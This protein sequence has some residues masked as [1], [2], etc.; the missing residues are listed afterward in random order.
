MSKFLYVR[1]VILIFL[2][3]CFQGHPVLAC[4]YNVRETGFI[5]L[6]ADPYY[7]YG[8]VSENTP[9]EIISGF[10]QISSTLLVDCNIRFEIININQQKDHPGMKFFYLWQIQSFPAAILVSP[11]GQSLIIPI[12]E[13]NEPFDKTLRSAI[14]NIVM[15]P[16]RAEIIGKVIETYGVILLVKGKDTRE[17]RK[18]RETAFY[19]IAEIKKQMRIMPKSITHPPVL[20]VIEPES[21]TREKILLWSLGLDVDEIEKPYA[22]VFY[23]RA[24][25]IGPLMKAEE[26]SET[27][28]INILSIVG[29]DCECGF[30]VSWVQG[31]ILPI[32]W[33]KKIQA[34]ATESLEF[35]PE[36]P[37]VKME[38]N[39]I[40]RM[41][42]SSY[43]GVPVVYQD[44]PGESESLS[45][46]YVI[47]ENNSRLKVTKYFIVGL[48]VIITITALFIFIRATR[49]KF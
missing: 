49:S 39:H 2:W 36:N 45:E 26:I 13:D 46:P 38:V 21:F 4:R 6:G 25:W 16:I 9:E 34:K 42:L 11:D 47:D 15:S 14:D 18:Y 33:D 48:A 35:D 17:N 7:L 31:T 10:K 27:N 23:G 40:L 22:A 20:I 32:R 1:L 12:K 5:D 24:R 44:I 37:M 30:D 43:P 41:G 28:L 19:A 3:I 29:A 8:Y